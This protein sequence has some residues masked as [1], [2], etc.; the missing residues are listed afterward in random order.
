MGRNRRGNPLNQTASFGGVRLNKL[1]FY[2]TL[3]EIRLDIDFYL[4]HGVR[5]VSL[6]VRLGACLGARMDFLAGSKVQGAETRNIDSP[7]M[8]P[9][10]P[11]RGYL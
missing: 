7:S 4:R 10:S 2:G 1:H 8:F 5:A 6:A 11:V 3:A 9:A